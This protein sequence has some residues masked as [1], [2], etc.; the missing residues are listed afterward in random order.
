MEKP[1]LAP[2]PGPS[3]L[4]SS[5]CLTVAFRGVPEPRGPPWLELLVSFL[6]VLF[7]RRKQK[8][9]LS[10]SALNSGLARLGALVAL[11]EDAGSASSSHTAAPSHLLL[12]SRG[13]DILSGHYS[14]RHMVDTRTCRQNTFHIK[15]NK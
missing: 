1:G 3:H 10:L 6:S 11:T 9:L 4:P 13:S 7:W 2:A 8:V 5:L 12:S 15:Y 14:T